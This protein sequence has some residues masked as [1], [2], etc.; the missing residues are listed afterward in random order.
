MDVLIASGRIRSDRGILSLVTAVTLAL[1]TTAFAQTPPPPA[2][3]A[4]K[5]QPQPQPQPKAQPKAPPQ[6]PAETPQAQPQQQAGGA[7]LPPLVWSQW[8]KLCGKGQEENAQ[9]LC[10]T[11]RD[12]RDEFGFPLITT[13]LYEP[14]GAPKVLRV[15]LPL[16][17]ALQRGIRATVDDGQPMSAQFILCVPGGCMADIEASAELIGKLKKGQRFIVQ[18]IHVQNGLLT[19]PVPLDTFA[20]A[21]EGAP[22]DAKVFQD[23]EQKRLEDFRKHYEEAQKKLEGQPGQQPTPPTR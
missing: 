16:G 12:G 19:L 6:K 20:K 8:T 7:Q 18:G 22:T 21:N 17:M 1:A 2:Q 3:P 15:T 13:E 11:R 23:R 4:P 14:E 9:Q 5:A 10:I